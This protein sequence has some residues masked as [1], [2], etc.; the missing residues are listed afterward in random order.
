MKRQNFF[1]I[2]KEILPLVPLILI[3]AW[4]LVKPNEAL[5]SDTVRKKLKKKLKLFY[6]V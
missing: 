3:C 1:Q 4:V 5:A 2:L 6:L